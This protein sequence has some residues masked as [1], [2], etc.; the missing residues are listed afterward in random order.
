MFATT[1]S[2][3]HDRTTLPVRL[4]TLLLALPA[5]VVSGATEASSRSLEE[6]RGRIVYV[7]ATSSHGPTQYAIGQVDL[8]RS[9]CTRLLTLPVDAVAAISPD[10]RTAAVTT[11]AGRTA[12]LRLVTLATRRGRT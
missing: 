3:R 4:A 5:L 6:P 9:R 7:Y 2:S 1:V 12:D 8:A 11:V 10:G